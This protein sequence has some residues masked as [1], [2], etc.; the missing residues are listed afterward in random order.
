LLGQTRSQNVGT[1]L[2]QTISSPAHWAQEHSVPPPDPDE[3]HYQGLHSDKGK[4]VKA[5]KHPPC[6]VVELTADHQGG[7]GI[8]M[9]VTLEPVSI[10]MR[11]ADRYFYIGSKPDPREP[12]DIRVH[13]VSEIWSQHGC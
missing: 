7:Q 9:R 3:K 10:S 5:V 4:G 6:L 12:E 2:I 1:V 13:H 11:F 8:V